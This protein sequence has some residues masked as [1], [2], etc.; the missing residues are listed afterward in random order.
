MTTNKKIGY[1]EGAGDDVMASL[2]Q[3]GYQVTLLKEE[4]IKNDDLS[5]FDVIVTG[6]S[7]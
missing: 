5:K 4:N 7:I 6:V 1:I 3:M 2:Q